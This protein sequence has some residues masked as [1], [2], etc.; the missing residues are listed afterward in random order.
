MRERERETGGRVGE[1]GKRGGREEEREGRRAWG[2][3][4][5]IETLLAVACKRF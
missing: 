3:H 5:D 2:R 1:G 4:R